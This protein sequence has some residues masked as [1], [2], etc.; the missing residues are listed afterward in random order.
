MHHHDDLVE[1]ESK[2]KIGNESVDDIISE[3]VT[4]VYGDGGRRHSPTADFIPS[5]GFIPSPRY[6]TLYKPNT[7]ERPPVAVPVTRY[8][9]LKTQLVDYEEDELV[10]VL[11]SMNEIMDDFVASITPPVS[12]SCTPAKTRL[13]LSVPESVDAD[14]AAVI[15]IQKLRKKIEENATMETRVLDLDERLTNEVQRRTELECEVDEL[16]EK[17]LAFES[18]AKDAEAKASVAEKMSAGLRKMLDDTEAEL[19]RFRKER[20]VI[21]KFLGFGLEFESGV[22]IKVCASIFKVFGRSS[23][24]DNFMFLGTRES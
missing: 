18:R 24:S 17:M 14:E 7:P 2:N 4:H 6:R 10:F 13:E 22:M 16:N 12:R 9:P 15:H 8:T 19:Q 3:F 23:S 1:L 20:E 5:P 11:E 21:F